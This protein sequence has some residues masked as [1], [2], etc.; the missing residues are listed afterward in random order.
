MIDGLAMR[1]GQQRKGV[2]HD[3]PAL[4]PRSK[5]RIFRRN[6]GDREITVVAYNNGASVTLPTWVSICRR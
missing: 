3:K 1:D 6:W 4:S 5:G 2:A